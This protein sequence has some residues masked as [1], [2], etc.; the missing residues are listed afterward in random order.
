VVGAGYV[1][2]LAGPAVVG[3]AAGLVGLSLAFVL[4]LAFCVLAVAIAG[5][6]TPRKDDAPDHSAPAPDADAHAECA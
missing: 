2:Q 5:I 1:G 4:P 3:A 6:V